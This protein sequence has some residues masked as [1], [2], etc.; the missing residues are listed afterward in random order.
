MVS[1]L[2]P[3]ILECEVKW[4]LRSTAVNKDSA[5]DD[6]PAKLFK[7]L[8]DDV[9]KILHSLCQQ[10]WKTQQWHRTGKC[11]SS[12]QFQRRA[13]LKNVLTARQS[14]S[15][16]MLVRSCL[17]IPCFSAMQAR[18]FQMAKLGLEKEEKLE[19]KLPTFAEL[20]RKQGN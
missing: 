11:K 19:I 16:P 15:S 1:N 8:K 17:N 10:I 3:N 5:L 14:H 2:E 12:S 20:Q 6:I 18:N 4:A 7:S 9:I 13:V